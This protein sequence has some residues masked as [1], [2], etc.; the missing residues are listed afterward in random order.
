MLTKKVKLLASIVS[1]TK[2]PLIPGGVSIKYTLGAG[3]AFR[4]HNDD[5]CLLLPYIQPDAEPCTVTTLSLLRGIG[6]CEFATVLLGVS[7]NTSEEEIN[8]LLAEQGYTLTLPQA[9]RMTESTKRRLDTRMDMTHQTFFYTENKVEE[10]W[11]NRSVSV[12]HVC[13]EHFAGIESL[14][15]RHQ[16]FGSDLGMGAHFLIRNPHP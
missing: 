4:H 2:L 5:F 14:R 16:Y 11:Q 15:R 8:R 12:V 3:V 1:M 13:G 10:R 6:Y 7:V 9:R